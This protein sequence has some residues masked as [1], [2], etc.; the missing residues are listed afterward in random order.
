MIILIIKIIQGKH[1]YFQDEGI[2]AHCDL[3]EGSEEAPRAVNQGSH[4]IDVFS[5]DPADPSFQESQLSS[6]PCYFMDVDC[7]PT[8]LKRL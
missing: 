5:A 2:K 7:I 6:H 1:N 8:L 4:H 3:F